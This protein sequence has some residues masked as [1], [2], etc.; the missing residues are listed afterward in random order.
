MSSLYVHARTHA[1]STMGL[2]Q[3]YRIDYTFI[4]IYGSVFMIV[5]A[6]ISPYVAVG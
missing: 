6:K 4:L 1:V 3:P 5:T 2:I